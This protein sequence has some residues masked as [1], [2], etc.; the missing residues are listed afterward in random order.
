MRLVGIPDYL[1]LPEKIG[2]NPK[3]VHV[4]EEIGFIKVTIYRKF[5]QKIFMDRHKLFLKLNTAYQLYK[6]AKMKVEVIL[7]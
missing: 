5:W 1:R 4:D 3:W 7:K 6:P 2:Y